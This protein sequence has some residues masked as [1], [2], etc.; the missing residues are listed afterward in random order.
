M[1][2]L[3]DQSAIPSRACNLESHGVTKANDNI[4]YVLIQ[5]HVKFVIQEVLNFTGSY[6]YF[7]YLH[8]S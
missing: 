4:T 3:N 1:T 2:Q 6:M 5:L 8:K 7:W